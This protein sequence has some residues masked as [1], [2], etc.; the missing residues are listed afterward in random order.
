MFQA[1]PLA[2]LPRFQPEEPMAQGVKGFQGLAQQQGG[3]PISSQIL[4]QDVDQRGSP[5]GGAISPAI[6]A[7]INS[8]PLTNSR[9]HTA[10]A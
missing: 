2:E 8:G 10:R 6:T 7:R 4:P 9:A 3:G 5:G 1:R